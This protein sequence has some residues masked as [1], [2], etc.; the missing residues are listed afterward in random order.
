[1][2]KELWF[3]TQNDELVDVY[4]DRDI[5]TEE[6]IYLKEDNPLDHITIHSIG[7]AELKN[8]HDEY[9]FAMERGMLDE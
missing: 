9:E 3:L 5:A 8:Y 2:K 4:N 7:F 1:M 6:R